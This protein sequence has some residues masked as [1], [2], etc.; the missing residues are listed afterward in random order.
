MFF[1]LALAVEA[2]IFVSM[3]IFLVTLTAMCDR[4]VEADRHE[5]W[6]RSLP[7]E[8][9]PTVDVFITYNEGR[10]F[11]ERGI[12]QKTKAIDYP[13]F[14]VWV[15]DD[16]R[17][18]WLRD[19]CA[20]REVGY[21]PPDNKHAKAGNVNHALQLTRGELFTVFDADF[22]PIAIFCTARSVSSLPMRGSP[23]CRHRSIFSIPTCSRSTWDWPMSC[24]TTSASGTT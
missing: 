24:R 6:L 19:L 1:F 20:A 10:E 9:L 21:R 23:S 5:K 7:A 13:R 15:L 14:K 2:L 12:V 22:T 8:R 11:V 17:H 18:N 16:G 4:S 3:G